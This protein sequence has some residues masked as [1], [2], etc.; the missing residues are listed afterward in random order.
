MQAVIN[1]GDEAILFE[2]FYDAYPAAIGM[3]KR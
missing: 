3:N 2:P 1:P